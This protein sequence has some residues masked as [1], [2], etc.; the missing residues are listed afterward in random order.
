M[1][2]VTFISPYSQII[3]G[4]FFNLGD[5]CFLT[6]LRNIFSIRFSIL[7][8]FQDEL[9]NRMRQAGDK[10]FIL[11][12]TEDQNSEDTGTFAHVLAA[13]AANVVGLGV[14]LNECR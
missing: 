7:I 1:S 11:F 4:L 10:L 8:Y 9:N 5:L 6:S 2:I 3:R 12:F 14:M 13:H